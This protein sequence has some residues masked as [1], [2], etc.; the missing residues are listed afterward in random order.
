MKKI[1]LLL[2]LSILFSVSLNAQSW[3]E[4]FSGFS[5]DTIYTD[6]INIGSP[7]EAWSLA[8][9]MNDNNAQYQVIV[10]TTDGGHTWSSIY[11]VSLPGTINP[12]LGMVFSAGN[13]VA[14]IAAFKSGN[15]GSNGVWKTTDGGANWT[16]ITSSN[17]Y[18]SS[19]SFAN[20]V[21]F[22]DDQNGLTCGDPGDNG[23]FE[24][25]LTH[26][27]GATWSQVSGDNIPNPVNAEE[28]GYVHSYAAAGNSFW[29]TTNYGRIF[30]TSDMGNTWTVYQ[31]PLDDFGGAHIDGHF[32]GI[33]FKDD[34]EG[35]VFNQD[36]NLYHTTNGGAT[37]NQINYTGEFFYKYGNV[38]FVPGT[39]NT[40]MSAGLNANS[41]DVKSSISTD[42]GATWSAIDANT[43]YHF[44]V[45]MLNDAVGFSGGRSMPGQNN[46]MFYWTNPNASVNESTI[47]GLKVFPN[48]ATN[49]VNVSVENANIN[50]ITVFDITGKQVINLKGMDTKTTTI[51]TSN[52]E[53]G[54][55]LMKIVDNDNQEQSL[56]LVIK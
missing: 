48:P 52:L 30:K 20:I 35:W 27:A 46:G 12:G 39:S 37:W 31:T 10:K 1:L 25:Y 26:D 33:T 53:N 32:G 47:E 2:A 4:T 24:I 43:T 34:N 14:Y 56:K 44:Y 55:Y 11:P 49:V 9:G 28:F 22:F 21:Y 42:G 13:D 36:G 51:N 6:Y 38:T 7:Q 40:L 19:S 50:Q 8:S 41:D 3:T 23:E 29:F 5:S 54:V 16:K 45:A 18:D 15:F 17:V